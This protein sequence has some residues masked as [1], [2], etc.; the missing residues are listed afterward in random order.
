[1]ADAEV[2][3]AAH[4]AGVRLDVAEIVFPVI[5]SRLRKDL[6]EDLRSVLYLKGKNCA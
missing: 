2:S 5:T 6:R 1:M 4:G 3:R